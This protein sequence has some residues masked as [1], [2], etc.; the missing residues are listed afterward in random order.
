MQRRAL[1]M[2]RLMLLVSAALSLVAYAISPSAAVH[3]ATTARYLGLLGLATP[4]LLWPV[5]WG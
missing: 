5:W 4:A 2:L 1:H 3:P